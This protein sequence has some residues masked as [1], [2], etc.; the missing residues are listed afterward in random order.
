MNKKKTLIIGLIIFIIVILIDQITKLLFIDK[1]INLIPSFLQLGYLQD[2]TN[3]FSI[4]RS[5]IITT[6]ITD[7]IAVI[8]ITKFIKEQQNEMELNV[9]ISLFIILSGGISNLIDIIF[10]GH[11]IDFIT[12]A[13][14]I[15]FNIADIFIVIAILILFSVFLKA[16]FFT[17]EK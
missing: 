1:N 5:D 14:A 3:T 13:N 15:S 11:T 17:K 16:T 10:R 4:N 7:V 2:N 6:L 12:I 9:L 8:I